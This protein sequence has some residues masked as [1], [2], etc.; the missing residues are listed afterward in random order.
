[1]GSYPCTSA[2]A[3]DEAGLLMNMKEEQGQGEKDRWEGD[4]SKDFGI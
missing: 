3:K 2:P 4:K 1:M